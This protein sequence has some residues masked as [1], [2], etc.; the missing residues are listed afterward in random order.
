M[1][2]QAR[3][4]VVSM[5]LV[6]GCGGG[7]PADTTSGSTTGGSTTGGSTTIG[8]TT[9]GSTTGGSTTGGS[10]TGGSTTGDSTT[11]G[12][13]TGGSTTG[14]STTGGSTT[15]GSTT[16]GGPVILSFGTNVAQ[17]TAGE[18]VRFVAVVTLAAGLDH[19]VGGN[20][21]DSTGKIQYG[22]FVATTQGSYQLDLSWS[23]INQA[24]P[25]DFTSEDQRG[26]VATFF[27]LAGDQTTQ[28]TMLR[29]HCNGIGACD[30]VCVDLMKDADNCGS[31]GN[32][33]SFPRVCSTGV[34]SCPDAGAS[35]CAD[36]NECVN[37]STDRDNCGACGVVTPP[38]ELCIGG[39]STCNDDSLTYC[40]ASLLCVDL[41]N[42]N[43]NCGA[44]GNACGGGQRCVASACHDEKGIEDTTRESCNTTCN[45]KGYTCYDGQSGSLAEYDHGAQAQFLSINCS[46][47][48]S[49]LL[50]TDS[51]YTF[52]FTDCVCLTD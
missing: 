38:V 6:A 27:D 50:P 7:G 4:M 30:G 15:G 10:T 40:A 13:T 49:G 28:T 44:C 43:S 51:S 18:S 48:P 3:F 5:M 26:F 22:A 33:V 35:Y 29:L 25:I 46:T 17:L 9:G 52:A 34:P 14:G 20:L 47:V 42:D 32:Q 37:L 39:V 16:G 45:A 8:S 24:A 36:S 31:C 41:T 1:K 19:L 11:G 21:T 12:S 23:Q 2:R